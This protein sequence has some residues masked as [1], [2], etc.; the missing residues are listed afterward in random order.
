M[1]CSVRTGASVVLALAVACAQPPPRPAS[2]AATSPG[3]E[4]AT[5]IAPAASAR[6][7]ATTDTPA[8]PEVALP[9][10]WNSASRAD[11]ARSLDGWLPLDAGAR[12]D[13]RALATLARALG[14]GD[15]TSVRA[16][17]ILGRSRDERA[18]E[19]LL[20]RLETRARSSSSAGDVVGAAA[21]ARG[22]SSADAAARL[23]ELCAGRTP[24]PVLDVRVE[25]AISSLALGRDGAIPFLLALLREG[26]AQAAQRPDWTRL[27]PDDPRL[28]LLQ[29]R[30]ARALS[31][32]AG[33]EC[34][35]RAQGSL[36]SRESEIVRLANLMANLTRAR[37]VRR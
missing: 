7:A 29:D 30:A 27:D 26:T 18:A 28:L 3:Q 32:R 5:P 4:D 20:A 10:D 15:E 17:V 8:R 1:E 2:P 11:F 21:F 16:A 34:T 14:A 6:E 22:L 25:C 36:A 19:I 35:F 31:D 33:I 12:L 13:E 37:E 23:V 9:A 24:H